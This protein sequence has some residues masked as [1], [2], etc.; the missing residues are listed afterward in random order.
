[1]TKEVNESKEVVVVVSLVELF[2]C[3]MVTHIYMADHPAG[4]IIDLQASS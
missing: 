2:E 4:P 3:L 1:M